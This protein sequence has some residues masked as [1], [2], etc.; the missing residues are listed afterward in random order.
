[1][2]SKFI[3]SFCSRS[4]RFRYYL[5]LARCTPSRTLGFFPFTSAHKK[6]FSPCRA[7]R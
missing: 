3:A 1:M 6:L 7:V 4:K 2:P 5:V